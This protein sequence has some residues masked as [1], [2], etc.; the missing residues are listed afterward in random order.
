MDVWSSVVVAASQEEELL[1]GQLEELNTRMDEVRQQSVSASIN[2]AVTGLT[3]AVS[4]MGQT[5]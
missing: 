3:E 2:A 5:V 1:R 4:T